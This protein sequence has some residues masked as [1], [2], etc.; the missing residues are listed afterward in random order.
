MWQNRFAINIKG[1][2]Y[3]RKQTALLCCIALLVS[4]FYGITVKAQADELSI[5]E[6]AKILYQINLLAGDG[7]SFN[8]DQP[9]RRCDAAAFLVKAMG[10]NVVVLQNKASYSKT[11]FKDVPENAWYAPYVGYM[12]LQG[13]ITGN[14]DGTFTPDAYISEKAFLTMLLKSMG[15]TTEDFSWNT[16]NA[17]AYEIG[18]V[19]DIGYVFKEDDNTNY[20]RQD[21]VN[22][23]YNSLFKPMKGTNKN[24]GQLLV[25]GKVISS[26]KAESLG[27]IK[28]DKLVTAVTD[29]AVKDYTHIMVNFN[30][31]I[32]KPNLSQ[33]QIYEKNSSAAKLEVKDISI[34]GNTLI[35]ETAPQTDKMEYV[36]ELSKINDVTGF[37]TLTLKKEFTGYR[38]AEAISAYFEISKVEPINSKTVN[39]YFTHPLTD[40]AEIELLYDI[41]AGDTR[42]VEGGYKTIMLSRSTQN[43]NMVTLTLK[44]G[45]FEMGKEYTVKVKGDLA[46]SYGVYLN[47]GQGSSMKFTGSTIVPVATKITQAECQESIYIYFSFSQTVDSKTALQTSSYTVREMDTNRYLTVNNVYGMKGKDKLNKNFVLKVS[48]TVVGKNYELI[49]NN[50]YDS[51]KN[52][53]LGEM[54]STFV[55]AYTAPQLLLIDSI[56]TIDS[57]TISAK[58]NRELGDASI[59]SNVVV[60][61]A[62]VVMK[63]ID[64]DDPTVMIIYLGSGAPM[65]LGRAYSV[66]FYTG[67]VDYVGKPPLYSLV[68][69]ALGNGATKSAMAIESAGFIGESSIMIKFNQRISTTQSI[70]ANQYDIYYNDGKT[71]KLLIPGT[72]EMVSDRSVVL[73]LPYLL[74]AGTYR[75]QA[76]NIY[77]ITNQIK[78]AVINSD[79]KQ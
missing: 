38:V 23:L 20:K 61:G 42:V 13:I 59:N 3:M 78:T 74:P 67:L 60:S 10:N 46:S 9:L 14:S 25:D 1:G 18:L 26:D 27:I 66:T 45:I 43:K 2:N 48:D 33:I 17:Y 71:E 77:D 4:Q 53:N 28:K 24:F 21:V 54:K 41:Y 76:K 8:L 64:P 57:T 65:Q 47:K 37:T 29:I 5:T 70:S 16:V 35:I 15:Y 51:N 44:D 39:I 49:A 32:E 52:Y 79:I 11:K 58:F 6:K 75:V 30:E 62:T 19:T 12:S 68:G 63:E 55:G 7:N 69:V 36:V 73:K 22:A 56:N 72:V 34:T 31:A 40:R 50:I